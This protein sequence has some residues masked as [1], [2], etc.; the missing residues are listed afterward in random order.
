MKTLAIDIETYSSVDLIKSG[1][2]AYT[3]A[4]DFEIRGDDCFPSFNRVGGC[5]YEKSLACSN[6][7]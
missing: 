6:S 2:Y 7:I 1:V 5:K 4:L 3:E